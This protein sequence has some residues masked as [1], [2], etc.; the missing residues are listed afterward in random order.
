MFKFLFL[1]R[2][3]GERTSVPYFIA[4]DRLLFMEICGICSLS[5]CVKSEP[6]TESLRPCATMQDLVRSVVPYIQR[7]LYYHEELSQ[8]HSELVDNNINETIR[9]LQF[10][11]V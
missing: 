6:Q 11:Q 1:L 2:T 8:V 3:L 9:R 5:Q 4:K 7:F 10:R